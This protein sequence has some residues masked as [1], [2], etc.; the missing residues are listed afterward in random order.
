MSEPLSLPSITIVLVEEHNADLLAN[1]SQGVFDN[2]VDPDLTTQYLRDPRNLL[3]VAV[4]ENQVVGMASGLLYL[5]PDKPLQLFINEV[6][7]SERYHR[8]GV[9]RRLIARLLQCAEGQGCTEAWVTTEEENT[10]AR[11]LYVSSAGKEE[12]DRPCVYTWRLDSNL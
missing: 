6:G 8:L 2:E 9:G 7:V 1:V 3:V 10:A 12:L 4:H 5:H 11:A